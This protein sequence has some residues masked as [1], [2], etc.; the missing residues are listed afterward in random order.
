MDPT[1][2]ADHLA[3]SGDA[4]E[5][6]WVQTNISGGSALTGPVSTS[7]SGPT[8]WTSDGNYP[9]VLVKGAGQDFGVYVNVK[10]GDVLT[11]PSTNHN[12]ILQA[13]SHV[14]RFACAT[15]VS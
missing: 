1:A 14:S 6:A 12:G 7:L 2:T 5:L 11:T 10:T 8:T 3:N 15:N 4:T 9:V 13:I